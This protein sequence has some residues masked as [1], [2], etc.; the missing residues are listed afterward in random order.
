MQDG[1]Y[2][3]EQALATSQSTDPYDHPTPSLPNNMD[4]ESK[5]NGVARGGSG[6]GGPHQGSP[7]AQTTRGGAGAGGGGG[8][9]VAAPSSMPGG[10]Q[11]RPA[12]RPGG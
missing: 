4:A 6:S 11:G 9:A 12:S 7:A 1:A 10:Q 2:L 3:Q 8:G 5:A